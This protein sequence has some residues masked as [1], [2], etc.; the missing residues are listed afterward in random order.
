[1]SLRIRAWHVAASIGSVAVILAIVNVAGFSLL[2]VERVRGHA[3]FLIVDFTQE[4]NIPTFF[5]AVML[6]IAALAA[7][8][9]ASKDSAAPGAGRW[10]P[11][12]R[13]LAVIFLFL[14]VDEA[15]QIHE[16]F[17]RFKIG[18][19]GDFAFIDHYSWM[20]VYV[21]AAAI[22]GLAFVPFLRSLP[23]R[24]AAL[25]VLS[26]A[27]YVTGAA[28]FELIGAW[29]RVAFGMTSGDLAVVL[30]S[31]AEETIESLGIALY[32]GAALEHAACDQLTVVLRFSGDPLV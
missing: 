28:G 1:M 8:A 12:W 4:A 2:G 27:L 20:L 9:N 32:I 31:V 22:A 30:R 7:A 5:S 11:G 16:Q 14:A 3:S 29:Q 13:A 18:A 6:I 23:R 10:L 19:T 15:A 24:T 25:L 17:S 26:G 21:P